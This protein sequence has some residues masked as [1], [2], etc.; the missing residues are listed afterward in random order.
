MIT[1]Y[2]VY[3][4]PTPSIVGATPSLIDSSSIT[5]HKLVFTSTDNGRA[6]NRG[7]TGQVNA[8][9][10]ISLC[11]TAAPNTSD[12]TVNSVDVSIWI[13]P[14]GQI[15]DASNRI[16]SSLT[17][18]AGETVFFNEERIILNAGDEIYVAAS[19]SSVTPKL[20]VIVSS[21]PV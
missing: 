4:N 20:S 14:N 13:V 17:I 2:I 5:D 7:G 6:T 18:P 1:N 3:P 11:N 12:E 16:V 21:I 9:T 8:I 19:N 10:T 15:V